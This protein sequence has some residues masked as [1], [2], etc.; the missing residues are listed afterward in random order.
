MAQPAFINQYQH[1]ERCTNIN[2][3][4]LLARKQLIGL[5]GHDPE[6]RSLVAAADDLDDAWR[7]AHTQ[8][9]RKDDSR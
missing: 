1:T 3:L 8:C 2:S 5:T 9:Q 7:A 6:Y 4:S